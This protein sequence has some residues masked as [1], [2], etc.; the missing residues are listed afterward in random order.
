MVLQQNSDS[1]V[2]NIWALEHVF[3]RMAELD[4][5][6]LL[7][8]EM[9][10]DFETGEDIDVF[11]RETFFLHRI[12]DPILAKHPNLKIV[13]EHITTKDAVD[14]VRKGGDNIAATITAHHLLVNRNH[15]LSGGIRPHL[16][17]LPILKRRKDRVAF[18]R[19]PHL[20]KHHSFWGQIRLL[21]L[22]KTKKTPVV[23]LAH[24]LHP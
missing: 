13:L 9:L 23:V 8:G 20:E 5:L 18:W 21:I 7:H 16:Y 14:F 17:C 15:M 19:L 6:L 1:G 24:L 22:L 10:H 12:L 2:T 11:D 3:E 4:I